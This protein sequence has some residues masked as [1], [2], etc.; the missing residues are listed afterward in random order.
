[1]TNVYIIAGGPGDPDLITVKGKKIIDNA[2]HIFTSQRFI[3]EKIYED[4]KDNCKIYD[5]FAHSHEEKMDIVRAAVG[6]NEK[7]AFIT[8]GD[9]CL[10]GAIAG[11]I[12]RL[13]KAGINYEIV[14]GVSS[15][16]AASAIIKRGMTGLG[17]TNTAICTSYRDVQNPHSHLE[18]I[19][20]LKA[21]VALFMSVNKIA[22]ICEIFKRHY[23]E[24]T[25]V[26][27]VSKASWQ[28]EKIA[29]GTLKTITEEI[30]KKQIEDGIILIGD[31]INKEY[32]YELE[33]EFLERKRKDSHQGKI[34]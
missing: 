18:E 28:E 31:F 26:V 6:K 20:A 21:S 23:P 29:R 3:S 14:P 32:D 25:A 34:K 12:D 10:Y 24:D 30:N 2:D 19:A 7:V 27:V 17:I 15:F 16:N 5:S 1:M 13:D 9:P 8:M 22:E 33:K 11:T 4:K